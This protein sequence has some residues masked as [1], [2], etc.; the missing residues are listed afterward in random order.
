MLN[1]YALTLVAKKTEESFYRSSL[2]CVV[3]PRNLADSA[4]IRTFA[5]DYD[6]VIVKK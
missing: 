1:R 3:Y 4:T 5:V 2:F 6:L